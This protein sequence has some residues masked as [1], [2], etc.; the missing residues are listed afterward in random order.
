MFG[1][2]W[3]GVQIRVMIMIS[4]MIHVLRRDTG[5]PDWELWISTH[6]LPTLLPRY[7]YCTQPVNTIL[8][9]GS[10]TVTTITWGPCASHCWR[11][12]VSG[13]VPSNW[14]DQIPC[15]SNTVET[16]GDYSYDIITYL[17]PW[18][19]SIPEQWM[20]GLGRTTPGTAWVL[21]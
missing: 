8:L 16:P 15:I 2:A 1:H 20:R 5:V 11:K 9:Y 4:I 3:R 7:G 19:G 18:Q 6:S 10:D 12:K 13:V 21:D 17:D 14:Q